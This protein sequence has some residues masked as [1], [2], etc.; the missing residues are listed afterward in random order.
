MNGYAEINILGRKR[1]L[2]FGNYTFEKIGGLAAFVEKVGDDLYTF[3]FLVD[4]IHAAMVNNCM[5][6]DEYPDFNYEDVWDAIE[7]GQTDEVFAKELT[8]AVQTFEQSKPVQQ[9]L[10]TAK[11]SIKKKTPVGKKLKSSV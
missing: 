6:K 1:G 3:K 11:E 4:I 10:E 7:E 9:A 5:R 8:L 2:K